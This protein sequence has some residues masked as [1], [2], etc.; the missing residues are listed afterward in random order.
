MSFL[1]FVLVGAASSI[2]TFWASSAGSATQA[3]QKAKVMEE[4][5]SFDPQSLKPPKMLDEIAKFDPKSLRPVIRVEKKPQD[6]IG[7]GL[8]LEEIA[9]RQGLK[10]KFRGANSDSD[11]KD[12]NS[13]S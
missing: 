7:C 6:D 1:P 3:E 2:L 13:S 8:S 10:D 4:I 5:K 12:A 9:L 11:A